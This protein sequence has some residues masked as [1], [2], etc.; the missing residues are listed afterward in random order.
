MWPGL[1]PQ[2]RPKGDI[3]TELPWGH[4]HRV[5]TRVKFSQTVATKQL[6]LPVRSGFGV[7]ASAALTELAVGSAGPKPSEAGSG[8]VER[9]HARTAASG[10]DEN[11]DAIGKRPARQT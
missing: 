9:L 2:P 10:V 7:D 6:K 5:S 11:V 1:L 4:F 3:F 8:E